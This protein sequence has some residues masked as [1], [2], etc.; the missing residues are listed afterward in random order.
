MKHKSKSRARKVKEFIVVTKYPENYKLFDLR[1]NKPICYKDSPITGGDASMVLQEI[2]VI[3]SR[4]KMNGKNNNIEYFA[5]NNVGILLSIAHKSLSVA[6]NMFDEKINPKSVD[7]NNFEIDKEKYEQI[8]IR[9]KIIYDY[10]EQIQSSIVFGYTALEAFVNLSIPENYEYRFENTKGIVEIYNKDSIERWLPLKTKIIEI[11]IPIYKT[12][13]LKQLNTWSKYNVFEEHRN[14]II[15]QKTVN[16]TN[17][18]KKYFDEKIFEL[19]ST[20]QEII[21]FFFEERNPKNGTNALWPW[22][23]NTDNE[24]PVRYD[25]KSEHFEI[26]GNIYE[27]RSEK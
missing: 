3:E 6:K 5:P 2:D 13:P 10:I 20:P 9:S 15:H 27:G 8:N 16:H 22:V 21:K 25:Y 14:E 23:I 18:Y 24:F 7:H 1:T 19:C 26:V 4:I 17:F 11:L 12:K